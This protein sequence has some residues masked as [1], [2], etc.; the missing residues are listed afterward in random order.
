MAV[1]T[2]PA[3]LSPKLVWI[4]VN[5]FGSIASAERHWLS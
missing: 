5:L 4:R 2:L 1:A 3:R